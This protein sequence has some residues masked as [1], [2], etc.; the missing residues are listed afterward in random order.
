MGP[1]QFHA[2]L[3]VKEAEYAAGDVFTLEIKYTWHEIPEDVRDYTIKVYS[4]QNHVIKDASDGT[5][6]LHMDGQKPSGYVGVSGGSSAGG[7][8]GGGDGDKPDPAPTPAPTPTPTPA[9]TPAPAPV[10]AAEEP[11]KPASFFSLFEIAKTPEEFFDMLFENFWVVFVWFDL[12]W[13][14]AEA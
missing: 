10:A 3:V 7:G 2:A 6:M 14:S 9:P 5:N 11:K 4:K 12:G 13:G 1:D 8:G